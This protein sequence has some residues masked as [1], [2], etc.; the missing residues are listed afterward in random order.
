MTDLVGSRWW[1]FD[2][3]THTP[4]STDT[5]WHS[6]AGEDELTPSAWL[7]KYME[8][9]ID[10]VAI[11]DHNG[12]GWVDK[13][14]A[15]YRQLAERPPSWFRPCVLFPGVEI[16]VNQGFHILGIF[17]PLTTTDSIHETLALCGYN[18]RKGDPQVRTEKSCQDVVKII[19]GRGGICIPA[20][21]DIANG[22][23]AASD[24]GQ[25][26]ADSQTIRQIWECNCFDAVEIRDP[27]WQPPG[28]WNDLRSEL[29]V[30]VGSDCDN[31]RGERLPGDHFTW[32]KMG[33]PS[34]E[35]LQLALHDGNGTSVVRGETVADPNV[36]ASPI[37]ESVAIDNLKLMGRSSGAMKS[38]FSPWLTA[39]IGGRGSGKSTIIDSLRILF[40]RVGDLP[41]DMQPEFAEF[42][43]IAPEKGKR[44][45]LLHDTSISAIVLKNSTRFRLTWTTKSGETIIE[46]EA[47]SD[48]WEQDD[49][50]VRQRFR[51][52]ILSQKEVYEISR[53]PHALTNLIDQSEGL[54]LNDWR[55]RRSQLH[56]KFKR[57]RN[58]QRELESKIQPKQR[59]LGE[60][61]DTNIQLKVFEE[62]DNRQVL[63]DYQRRGRQERILDGQIQD[64]GR[65]EESIRGLIEEIAPNDFDEEQFDRD[66]QSDASAIKLI[67]D[68]VAKQQSA[69]AALRGMADDLQAFAIQ[70][71]S[72]LNSTSWATMKK[73]V[74]ERYEAVVSELTEAGVQDPNQYR[75]LVQQR[76]LIEGELKQID[77]FEK[78]LFEIKSES[79]ECLKEIAGHRKE[80]SQRRIDFLRETLTDNHFVRA[81]V[82]PFGSSATECETEFRR[83]VGC[84]Q[85]FERDILGNENYTGA[86]GHLFAA[87]PTEQHER[88]R[89][90]D[91]RLSTLKQGI[92][93]MAAGAD[94]KEYCTQSFA[95]RMARLSP[96][97]LDDVL[98]W[99]PDDVLK[100]EYCHDRSRRRWMPIEQGS[101]GQRSAAILAFLLSNETCP[102]LLD[103]PEDDL[104]NHLI[105]DLIVQQIR[106]KKSQR[107]IVTATHNPNIVVNGD[108]ELVLAMD[109]TTGQCK[110]NPQRSGSLQDPKVRAEVCDVMEGG[111]QA[112][113]KRY[114]RIMLP[115]PA[116]GGR[117]V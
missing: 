14:A 15:E 6:L 78:R 17:A 111:R 21:I 49:G 80:I 98:L 115:A 113:Q 53:D 22:L 84:D 25:V 40:D 7:R 94:S 26:N 34:F 18:G 96:E 106:E 89:V 24:S 104:D 76:A 35:G 48:V 39:L 42:Q 13:L 29:A 109:A 23:F 77:E 100:V 83:R 64:V 37:I 4:F 108:A 112:F 67:E 41:K 3:H 97:Q 88:S 66:V 90:L 92:E 54:R 52:R 59:L 110:V 47:A 102:I 50:D 32:V 99:F 116:D 101:P 82:V 38:P 5:P 62:G 63:L 2:F 95:K 45:L 105:Y 8:A 85:G 10:C 9:E 58:D 43:R 61:G 1:K 30:V 16:S 12:A 55:E 70:W 87:L 46:R 36:H 114:K 117:H 56:A 79:L 107:Q 74:D 57:L 27:N 28:L 20:H 73:R 33:Q 51:V 72:E 11:T 60:L 65:L 19:R 71:R 81:S 44:G 69:A 68:A 75:K 91:E 31:F 86:I 103:Q 93:E